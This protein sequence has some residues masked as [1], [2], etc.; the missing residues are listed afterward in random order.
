GTRMSDF[1]R[2]DDE[3]GRFLKPY[4]TDTSLIINKLIEQHKNIL[5]EGAQGT[6]LDIDHG[7]YPYVTSSNP[8]IGGVCTGLG[9]SPKK[10]TEILGVFKAY[11]TRVGSGALVTELGNEEILKS[12]NPD[13][14]VTEGDLKNAN[15]GDEYYQG[16]VLRK[17]GYEYGTTTGRARRCGWFDA[18]AGRYSITINGLDAII[19]TKLDVLT[20]LKKIKVCIGYTHNGQS[21]KDFTN[22]IKILSECKPVYEEFDGWEEEIRNVKSYHGLPKNAQNYLRRLGEILSVPIYIASV[23]AERDETIILDERFGFD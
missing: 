8:T 9:I 13:E 19:I 14:S 2:Q 15:N 20:G 3:M 18:V 10:I 11:I 7:T 16:R 6:L 23:G 5:L 22:D 1:I 21:I 12:E 4:V 17:N